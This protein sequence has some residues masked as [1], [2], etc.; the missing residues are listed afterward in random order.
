MGTYIENSKKAEITM[1][2]SEFEMPPMQDVLIVCKNAPIGPEAARRMVDILSPEQY[3]IIKV[4]HVFIEAIVI[5][6]SL[7]NILPKEKLVNLIIEEGGKIANESM[8]IKAQIDITIQVS[9]SI[10]L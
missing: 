2:L 5:R 10:D 1:R 7:L 3:E 4:N 9:K 6:K 8:I